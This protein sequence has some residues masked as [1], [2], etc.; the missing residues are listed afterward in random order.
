VAQIAPASANPHILPLS[1]YIPPIKA[2]TPRAIYPPTTPAGGASGPG[3]NAPRI[4]AQGPPVKINSPA[5]M[6]IPPIM[7]RIPPAF[8]ILF[9]SLVSVGSFN[10]PAYNQKGH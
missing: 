7:V 2:T 8:L 4:N 10:I 3:I 9:S 1:A 5:I 6:M